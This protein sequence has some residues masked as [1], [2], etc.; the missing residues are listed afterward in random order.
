MKYK[1]GDSLIIVANDDT[2][3]HF[4]IGCNCKVVK[5]EPLLNCFPYKVIADYEGRPREQ[6]VPESMLSKRIS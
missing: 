1:V 6:W 3:R 4:L 2:K 5:V